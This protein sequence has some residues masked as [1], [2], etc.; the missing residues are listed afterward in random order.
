LLS[1]FSAGERD[2]LATFLRT[3]KDPLVYG[4]LEGTSVPH[5]GFSASRR[6]TWKRVETRGSSW[7]VRQTISVLD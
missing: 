3:L 2:I 6:F 4:T 7:T 5:F 1:R